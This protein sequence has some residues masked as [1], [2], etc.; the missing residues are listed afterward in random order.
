MLTH[1][2]TAFFLIWSRLLF[3]V[4]FRPGLSDFSMIWTAVKTKPV[5]S[6]HRGVDSVGLCGVW[7]LH[8]SSKLPGTAA[9]GGGVVYEDNIPGT[10]FVVK[11]DRLPSTPPSISLGLAWGEKPEERMVVEIKKPLRNTTKHGS[12]FTFTLFYVYDCLPARM[13]VRHTG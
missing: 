7:W 9:A 3:C 2:S 5:C 10:L 13:S 4:H 11:V 8:V 6:A 12:L 1:I